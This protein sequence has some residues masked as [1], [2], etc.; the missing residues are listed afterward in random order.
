MFGGNGG[1]SLAD[2]AAVTGNNRNGDG[3][4]FGG[5]N[6]WWVLIILFALFG[7]GRNGFGNGNGDNCG[8]NGGGETTVVTVPT[9]MY[10]CYGGGFGGGAAGFTDAAIQR[11]FDN[12]TVIQKLDGINNGIC[13]LGY[14]QL[15]QM[16]G[17]NTNIMQTGFG[18]QQAINA[19]TVASMQ[20]TNAIMNQQSDCC[21]KTQTGFMN[22]INQMDKNACALNNNVHQTGDAIIQNQNQGFQMLNQTIKDGFC[23]LEKRTMQN[24]IDELRAKLNNCDRDSALQGTASYII[25]TVRPTPIPSW[26]VDNPWASCNCGSGYNRSGCGCGNNYNSC[27]A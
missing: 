26:N 2:I 12:Q 27:C 8:N 3:D 4:G 18:I 10:S 19:D 13:S 11:G 25:N 5:N 21:C 1:V 22:V 24:T 7:W 6:G 23:D 14:D 9:P 17:I 20:N 15:A 16:N